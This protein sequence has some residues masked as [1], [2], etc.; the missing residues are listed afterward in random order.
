MGSETFL[1]KGDRKLV[2]YALAACLHCHLGEKWR[3]NGYIWKTAPILRHLGLSW[4]SGRALY[5]NVGPSLSLSFM[6]PSFYC[7]SLEKKVWLAAVLFSCLCSP[8]K[9]LL[10]EEAKLQ[11][12]NVGCSHLVLVH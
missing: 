3:N 11:V 7:H 2:S 12:M 6:W 1:S 8:R 4:D 5:K 9:Q 10:T